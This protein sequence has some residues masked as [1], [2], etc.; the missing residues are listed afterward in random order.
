MD[1]RLIESDEKVR[2]LEQQVGELQCQ[3]MELETST[4][5]RQEIVEKEEIEELQQAVRFSILTTI[6]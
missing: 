3:V 1:C 5:V 4:S 2:K 6:M